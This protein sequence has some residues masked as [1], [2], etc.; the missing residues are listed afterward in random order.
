MHGEHVLCGLGLNK[1][2][3]MKRWN[4]PFLVVLAAYLGVAGCSPAP[5]TYVEEREKDFAAWQKR[6]REGTTM[7]TE[8]WDCALCP[9]LLARKAGTLWAGSAAWDPNRRPNEPALAGVDIV[10]EFALGTYEV[11]RGEYEAFVTATNRKIDG[12]CLTDRLEPGKWAQDAQ[13]SFRD[14]GFPQDENHPAVCV[15]RED[16]QDYVAWLNTQTTGGYRLPIESEWQFGTYGSGYEFYTW[17]ETAHAA[18]NY[19]NGL[20]ESA[21]SL[22]PRPGALACNDGAIAT[23]PV[24]N[25]V[26][27]ASMSYDAI[28]NAAEWTASCEGQGAADEAPCARAIVRGGSWRSAGVELRLARRTAFAPDVRDNTIGFRV[29]KTL[30]GRMTPLPDATAYLARGRRKQD[31]LDFQQALADF[32][33]AVELDPQNAHALAARGW[34]KFRLGKTDEA[35]NDFSAALAIDASSAS[36]I[37]GLGTAALTQREFKEA[38]R[39]LDKALSLEPNYHMAVANR[40][41]AHMAAENADLAL[42]DSTRALE[43]LPAD[44]QMLQIRPTLRGMRGEWK[45]AVAEVDEQVRVFPTLPRAQYG[46]ARAYSMLLQ[47]TA[48]LLAANRALRSEKTADN[49]MLRADVRPWSDTAGRRSDINAAL[50]E[51][52][53]SRRALLG[54]GELESRL[55]NHEAARDAFTRILE[56][57]GDGYL[58]GRALVMRGIEYLKLQDS[59]AANKDFEAFLGPEASATNLNNLC[60]EMMIANVALSRAANYCDR[61]VALDPKGANYLDSKAALHL[62][63]GEWDKAIKVYDKALALDP[64]KAHSLY[65]RGIASQELCQCETGIADLQK[66][67]NLYPAVRREFE[68]MG[69]LALHPASSELE[70]GT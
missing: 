41:Y 8:I 22:H 35:K 51:D 28:G 26:P 29:A 57:G 5:P 66:A 67:L 27:A 20:D 49:F 11:T 61:A 1:K 46:A 39:Q 65:G 47:D 6:D 12:G 9:K 45:Q 15:S 52:P 48:A 50:A 16:A 25:Y 44:I 34:G 14:P 18:C 2:N 21:S 19:A 43:L 40:A 42:A 32:E 68:R 37:A 4:A 62:R 10:D 55:G 7:G 59:A 36:A 54:L 63:L 69:F 31:Q 58:R 33:K 23:A 3:T 53:S 38:V 64:K 30:G 17:G 60:W 56:Q 70:E 24:G 13:A